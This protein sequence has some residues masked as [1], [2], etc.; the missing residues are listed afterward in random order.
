MDYLSSYINPMTW[1]T[2]YQCNSYFKEWTHKERYQ[3]RLMVIAG[4]IPGLIILLSI[5]LFF[6][7]LICCRLT[8][9]ENRMRNFFNKVC[10]MSSIVMY[11]LYPQVLTE[12]IGATDCF[13][14]IASEPKTDVINN[15]LKDQLILR[16]SSLP[17]EY[18]YDDDGNYLREFGMIVFPSIAFYGVLL[19]LFLIISACK[20]SHVIY[21]SGGGFIKMTESSLE[22]ETG[23]TS[24]AENSIALL[25][26]ESA[27][28]KYGFVCSGL[29]ISRSYMIEPQKPV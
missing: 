15:E 16:M 28:N 12:F 26:E 23:K 17:D 6:N 8:R 22:S 27:R 3:F 7:G 5:L 29:T 14:S 9:G 24:D 21:K 18:C 20:Q 25:N 11:L 1:L 4:I 13:R 19:P 10:L 2:D